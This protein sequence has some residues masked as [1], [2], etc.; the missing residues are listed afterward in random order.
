MICD[1]SR[2]G[3]TGSVGNR[4]NV[5]GF[6]NKERYEREVEVSLHAMFLDIDGVP[7]KDMVAP[8]IKQMYKDYWDGVIKEG[9]ELGNSPELTA[10]TLAMI[11][12]QD[13]INNHAIADDVEKIRNIILEKNYNDEARPVIMFKLEVTTAVASGWFDEELDGDKFVLGLRD[14]HRAIFDGDDEHLNETIAYF[15]DGGN[16]IRD[17]WKSNL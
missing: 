11:F 8:K 16:R 14:I 4:N 2:L 10:F 9:V 5:F 1:T 3:V 13:M 7:D 17:R 12:Y 6:S 15:I